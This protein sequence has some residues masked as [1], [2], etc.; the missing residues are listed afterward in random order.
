MTHAT[1]GVLYPFLANV[2]VTEGAPTQFRWNIICV[3]SGEQKKKQ[4]ME[5]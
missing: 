3:F 5:P 4:K 2:S 1:I